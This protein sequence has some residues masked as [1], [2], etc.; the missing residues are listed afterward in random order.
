MSTNPKRPATSFPD[1][2]QMLNLWLTTHWKGI[3]CIIFTGLL[4][5]GVIPKLQEF[6]KEE[7][8]AP[9]MISAEYAILQVNSAEEACR[10]TNS[11]PQDVCFC[12]GWDGKSIVTEN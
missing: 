1:W 8:D 7:G 10:I 2:Q 5:E 11:F 12:M 9:S 3:P 4:N 6:F